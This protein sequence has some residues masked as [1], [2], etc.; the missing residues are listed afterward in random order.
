MEDRDIKVSKDTYNLIRAKTTEL[1]IRTGKIFT[2]KEYIRTLVERDLGDL[3]KD[4][5]GK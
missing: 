2:I 1:T 3:T 4:K 5:E